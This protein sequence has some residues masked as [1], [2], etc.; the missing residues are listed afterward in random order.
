MAAASAALARPLQPYHVLEAPASSAA[1][2]HATASA[3]CRSNA[4]VTVLVQDKTTG[5][6]ELVG[7]VDLKVQD[8]VASQDQSPLTGEVLQSRTRTGAHTH[9]PTNAHT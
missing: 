9:A 2:G 6:E 4:T 8:V 7:R 3:L 1:A 5:V